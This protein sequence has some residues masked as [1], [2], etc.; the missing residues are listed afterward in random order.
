MSRAE[1]IGRKPGVSADLD[2][3]PLV[4]GPPVDRTVPQLAMSI[5]QFA[6]A[7]G[8]SASMYFKLKKQGLTPREMKVGSR[9]LITFEAAAQWRTEREAASGTE[10]TDREFTPK[11]GISRSPGRAWG[12]SGVPPLNCR[13][14]SRE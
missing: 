11:H 10:A 2:P 12:K 7:H 14:S 5:P 1:V 3:P 8:I 6:E 4:R 13:R 9:T